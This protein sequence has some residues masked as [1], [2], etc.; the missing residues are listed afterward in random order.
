MNIEQFSKEH[1]SAV[2]DALIRV[3]GGEIALLEYG[4]CFNVKELLI[5]EGYYSYGGV[6]SDLYRRWVKFSGDISY[7]VPDPRGGDARYAYKFT[8]SLW[9]GEQGALRYELLDFLIDELTK[10]VEKHDE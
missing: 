2:L 8:A 9:E 7:P 6:L 4:I 10:V 3:K 1:L 5:K